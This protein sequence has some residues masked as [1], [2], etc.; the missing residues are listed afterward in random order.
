MGIHSMTGYGRAEGSFE[1]W[2]W[3]WETRA[4]NGKT[5]DM[6]LR[7]PTGFESL[8]PKIRKK[9]GAALKRGNLQISL[10]MNASEGEGSYKINH[11]W[12]QTLIREGNDI[13]KASGLEPARLDGLYLVR[14][15]ISETIGSASDP[16]MA[17]RNDAILDSLGDML[18]ALV[19][20]RKSEGEAMG[21]ILSECVEAFETL[22]QDARKCE[23]A[24]ASHIQQKLATRVSELLSEDMPEDRLMQ[25]AALLAVK[26][27]VREE[28]DRLD[29]HIE[30]AKTLIQKGSPIGRKLDFLSQEFIREINTLCSKSTDIDL[31]RTGLEMKSLIEQFREQAANV[32]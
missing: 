18:D 7:L 20:A 2:S 32:E 30:Q 25:E 1:D 15:V 28:L 22:T 14:G 24:Q 10:T 9:V 16:L 29:A 4:V 19:K 13:A 5:L 12:L 8:D 21:N 23:S 26:A 17:E 11:D 6:R 27:D 3:V 31:T